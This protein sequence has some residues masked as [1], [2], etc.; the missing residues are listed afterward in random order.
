MRTSAY[1]FLTCL[2]SGYAIYE[3]LHLKDNVVCFIMAAAIWAFY[4]WIVSRT[5]KKNAARRLGERIFEEHMRSSFG[6][7]IKF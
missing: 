2:A 4:A 3:G 5:M 6:T 1:L 7:R